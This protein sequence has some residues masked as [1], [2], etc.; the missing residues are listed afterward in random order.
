MRVK[1]KFTLVELLMTV[2]VIAILTALLLPAL[3]SARETAFQIRCASNQKQIGLGVNMYA[4]AYDGWLLRSNVDKPG[5]TPGAADY[6]WPGQLFPFLRTTLP[7]LCPQSR[8][9]GDNNH[10]NLSN[11]PWGSKV[12]GIQ[13][14]G[15][16]VK[17]GQPSRGKYFR[18]SRIRN[19]SRYVHCGDSVSC[20]LAY[21]PLISGGGYNYA[22]V[23][24]ENIYPNANK[25][26]YMRHKNGIET[27]FLDGHVGHQSRSLFQFW[28]SQASSLETSRF[29]L[30]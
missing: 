16:N 21:Y 24:Y 28:L 5:G 23:I 20:Q 4:G 25:S 12:C 7:F 19:L 1:C 14:I 27:L 26:W 17:L 30:E 2:A 8:E 6:Y 3:N 29:R 22:A 13:T 15:M 10:S 9:Y 11:D 18:L